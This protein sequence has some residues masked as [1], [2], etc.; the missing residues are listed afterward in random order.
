MTV[1]GKEVWP[2]TKVIDIP[3]APICIG[4]GKEQIQDANIELQ[5]MDGSIKTGI[6]AGLDGANKVIQ[7]VSSKKQQ[8]EYVEFHDCRYVLFL[9][10]LLFTGED[11]DIDSFPSAIETQKQKQPYHIVFSD[12]E[13]INGDS[14]YTTIDN[15]GFHIF[16]VLD[17]NYVTRLFIPRQVVQD[18]DV[19]PQLGDILKQTE[20]ISDDQ[21]ELGVKKQEEIRKKPLGEYLKDKG[22]ID[23]NDL[24]RILAKQK[25]NFDF[26]NVRLGEL[27]VSE[28]LIS[29]EEL[30]EALE[31]QTNDRKRRLG[32][33]LIGIGATTEEAIHS[34]L[35]QK[36]CVPFVKL[37]EFNLNVNVLQHIPIN[38]AKKEHV[39]PLMHC[40]KRLVVAIPDPTLSDVRQVLDFITNY[41]IE[42]V[43]STPSDIDWAINHYYGDN[44]DLNVHQIESEQA[45]IEGVAQDLGKDLEQMANERPIVRLVHNLLVESIKRG[46]SDIHIRPVSN[47][48]QVLFRIHGKLVLIKN[49]GKSLLPAIVSRIKVISRM[50]IAQRRLPQDGRTQV[51]VSDEKTDMRVSTMP[52]VEGE[53]VVIRILANAATLKPIEQLGFNEND[54]NALQEILHRGAGM[55]LVTGPTGSGKSTT[56]YSALNILK[57][58]NVNIITVEDPV[59]IRMDGLE[60]IQVLPEIDLGF[61]RAL[62]NILRHDPDVIMIGEIR[63]EETAK[64]A[65]KAAQTGHFVLSTLHTNS[66]AD[67]IIRLREMHI[68]PYMIASSLLGVIA[69]RLISKNCE[70]CKVQ[71]EVTLPIRQLLGLSMEEMFYFGKGCDNCGNTGVSGR[72]PAYEF[73]QITSSMQQNILNNASSIELKQTAESWGMQSIV[74]CALKH[75]RNGDTPVSNVHRIF[76]T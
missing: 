29:E 66:A 64:I 39:M 8:M 6:L 23:E 40:G 45:T 27:L 14:A 56:L 38:I 76:V 36:L 7:F 33:I 54:T 20:S 25:N 71:E 59:E 75:A 9:S 53:S 65:I 41:S 67:T 43:V 44:F 37:K 60:Q 18:Y 62:R 21:L 51:V 11:A 61:G 52:T 47:G 22:I 34:A 24:E 35:A 42:L 1:C 49:F 48:I 12:G 55:L 58:M 68:E 19:G 74:E 28:G 17:Q 57:N 3:I 5:C 26:P 15:V 72:I 16:K 63:D 13:S 2:E 73:L 4:V 50:D 31:V 32:D 69:Q 30:S 46:A 10:E 70:F